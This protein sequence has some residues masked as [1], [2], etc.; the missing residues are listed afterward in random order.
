MC[1]IV[2]FYDEKQFDAEN[3]PA[4]IRK[5]NQTLIHR[6]PDEEGSWIKA[7]AAFGMRRLSIVDLKTGHQPIFNED[8]ALVLVANGEIYNSPELRDK[9]ERKGKSRENCLFRWNRNCSKQKFIVSFDCDAEQKGK[10]DPFFFNFHH[11]SEGHLSAS[12]S[13]FS[14]SILLCGT[15]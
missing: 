5:M 14:S 6:G 15:G 12:K 11:C 13:P 2:G 1:G 3:A 4:V 8:S 10:A 7:P 9:L